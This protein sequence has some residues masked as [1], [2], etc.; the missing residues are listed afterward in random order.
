[1]WTTLR[2]NSNYGMKLENN[3]ELPQ[4][5]HVQ[6]K[7]LTIFLCTAV[8]LSLQTRRLYHTLKLIEQKLM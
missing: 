7:M 2:T 3:V 5:G 8:Q 4:I 1:M 6:S